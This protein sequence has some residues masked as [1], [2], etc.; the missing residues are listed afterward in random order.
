MRLGSRCLGSLGAALGSAVI[1]LLA[2]APAA[3]AQAE[4]DINQGV[5]QPLPIAIP[6]FGGAGQVGA[7]IAKV[8][9]AD[10]ERSGLFKPLDPASLP[11]KN[12]D[13]SV[14]PRFDQW[15]PTGAQALAMGAA[16]VSSDG[17]L[18]V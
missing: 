4:V 7:D 9:A 16:N 15:K 18:V 3:W 6:N 1:C 5:V 10:L 8:V 11:E 13:I 12:P 2:A 14:P 17:R